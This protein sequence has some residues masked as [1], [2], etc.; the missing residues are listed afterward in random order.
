[1]GRFFVNR[2]RLYRH[3]LGAAV[4]HQRQP[5]EHE[6]GKG[7]LPEGDAGDYA[8]RANQGEGKQK[9]PR[10][11]DTLP[12]QGPPL[13]CHEQITSRSINFGS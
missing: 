13:G 7:R 6:P 3:G 1:M 11:A 5:G 10:A 2:R 8:E 12:E 9:R 4:G